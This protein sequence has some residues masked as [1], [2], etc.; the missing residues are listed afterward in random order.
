MTRFTEVPLLPP[1][2]IFGIVQELSQDPRNEKMNLCMGVYRDDDGDPVLFDV[3]RDVESRYLE[4]EESKDYLPLQG[5]HTFCDNTN[6]LV[7]GERNPHC[8]VNQTAGGT[9]ALRCGADFIK[10]FISETIILPSHTW[11]NHNQIFHDAGLQMLKYS[12]FDAEKRSVDI[13]KMLE[14]LSQLPEGS[15]VLLHASCHNPCGADPTEDEWNKIADICEERNFFPFFDCAYQGFGDGIDEDVISIRLFAERGFEF[16]VAYSYSKN[17]G[18]YGDRCGALLTVFSSQEV[19]ANLMGVIKRIVR[20]SYSNCPRHGSTIVNEVLK[21][22]EAPW[23]E[24]LLL[25]RERL[26]SIRRAFQ[27]ALVDAMP[28]YDWSFVTDQKGMFTMCGF[29][30]DVVE[31]LKVEHAIYMTKNARINI[32][33]IQINRI[34]YLVDALKRVLG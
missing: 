19:K 30:E 1:D 32:A 23:K 14:S 26:R 17:M 16:Q 13:G 8:Y 22:S 11:A 9:G 24:E 2:P 34:D 25:V 7:F 3:V 28:S 27:G 29:T 15:A 10:R 31:R 5:D 4:V 18:L 6:A 12:Y 20:T 21:K 33:G